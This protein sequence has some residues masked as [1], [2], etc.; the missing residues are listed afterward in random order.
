MKSVAIKNAVPGGV[1]LVFWLGE[2]KLAGAG[3]DGCVR[4]WNVTF[5]A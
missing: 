5:H 3:A 4:V 2:D 1:N